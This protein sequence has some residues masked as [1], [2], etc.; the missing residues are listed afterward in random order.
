L[1]VEPLVVDPA[2]ELTE[3][4]RRALRT[5]FEARRA[6]GKAPALYIC[7]P[8]VHWWVPGFLR[9]LQLLARWPWRLKPLVVDPASELTEPERRALQTRFEARRA[10]G[11]AP[12]LYICT[13]RDRESKHW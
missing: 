10:T 8:R 6:T 7:T 4:E 11:E 1:A 9:F 3:P 2:S 12:A 13:P 5:R